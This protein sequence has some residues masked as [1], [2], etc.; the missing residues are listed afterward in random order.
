MSNIE[1]LKAELQ[2]CQEQYRIAKDN[3]ELNK[4]ALKDAQIKFRIGEVERV[5]EGMRTLINIGAM[6]ERELDNYIVH[7]LNCLHGNVDGIAISIDEDIEEAQ[8]EVERRENEE[9]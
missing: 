6:N 4:E 7:C 8:A 1:D 2:Y 3:L 9:R 5:L